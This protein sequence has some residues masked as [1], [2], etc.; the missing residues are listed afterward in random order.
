MWRHS[1]RPRRGDHS[2]A[3]ADLEDKD[4]EIDD[5]LRAAADLVGELQVTVDEASDRL[6][7]ATAE[8]G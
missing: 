7:G 8:G 1:G 4:E 3:M 2:R 5:L 6:R